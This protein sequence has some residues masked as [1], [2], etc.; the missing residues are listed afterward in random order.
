MSRLLLFLRSHIAFRTTTQDT[1]ENLKYLLLSPADVIF[2]VIKVMG[3]LVA[4]GSL[5]QVVFATFA[6]KL[7]RL[8]T[9]KLHFEP[10]F[11]T[12][13]R[14]LFI[15]DHIVLGMFDE[16][17]IYLSCAPIFVEYIRDTFF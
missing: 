2:G 12:F 6:K 14:L 13:L 1:S 16:D 17:S 5:L 15:I 11:Q 10:S 4:G 3:S 8:S 7:F 9:S